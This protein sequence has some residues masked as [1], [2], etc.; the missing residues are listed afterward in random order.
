MLLGSSITSNDSFESKNSF[1]SFAAIVAKGHEECG[2]S[3]FVYSD[4]ERAIF[5]VFDGVSGE[6]NSSNASAQ[7]ASICL[8]K[9]KKLAFP[10][11]S[12]L[13]ATLSSVSDSISAGYTTAAILFLT[14]KGDFAIASVGDSPI[15]SVSK[16]YEISCEL[17]I[18][19]VVGEKD[20]VFKFIQY[21]NYVTSVL[22]KSGKDIQINTRIGKVEKGTSFILCSDGLSDNLYFESR[23]GQVYDSE[24]LTD[25]FYLIKESIEKNKSPKSI[26]D[27]LYSEILSRLSKGRDESGNKI[28]VPKEDDISIIF[29]RL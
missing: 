28:L 11:E 16:D 21:R 27:L 13:V 17:P 10:S 19:R 3:A 12:D 7:A 25:L 5:A 18:G 14:K 22:G 9:L 24:G 2:D 4:D 26:V 6:K 1:C 20:A 29:V 15:Y 23:E 8:E